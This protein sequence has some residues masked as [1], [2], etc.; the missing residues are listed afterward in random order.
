MMKIVHTQKHN[1]Y[2]LSRVW[3]DD[4]RLIERGEYKM[5]LSGEHEIESPT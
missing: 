5:W 2:D 3:M 4:D 1:I